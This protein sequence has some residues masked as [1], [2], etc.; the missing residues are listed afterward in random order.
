[1]LQTVQSGACFSL[2]LS[3]AF[4][5]KQA[6]EQNWQYN[7]N[8]RCKTKISVQGYY[9]IIHRGNETNLLLLYCILHAVCLLHTLHIRP[10]YSYSSYIFSNC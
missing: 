9:K 3:N 2:L 10:L 5:V 6:K 1:M 8:F 7:I 4:I